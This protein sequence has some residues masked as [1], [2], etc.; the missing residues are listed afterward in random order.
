M[1]SPPPAP[2]TAAAAAPHPPPPPPPAAVVVAASPAALPALPTYLTRAITV[3][4]LLLP[5]RVPVLRPG[6]TTNLEAVLANLLVKFIPPGT[7]IVL[8]G[9]VCGQ[10]VW[11]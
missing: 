9:R 1:S 6:R 10:C 11:S 4:A 5:V 2:A 7:H 3:L 8:A